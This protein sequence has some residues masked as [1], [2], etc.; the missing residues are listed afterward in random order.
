[1]GMSPDL[2]FIRF[3]SN[4]PPNCSNGGVSLIGNAQGNIVAHDVVE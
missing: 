4:P 2:A 3:E 1:M